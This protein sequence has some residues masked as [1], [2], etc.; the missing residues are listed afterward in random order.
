MERTWTSTSWPRR[1]RPDEPQPLADAPDLPSANASGRATCSCAPPSPGDT[2]MPKVDASN[3]TPA[4]IAEQ[5]ERLEAQGAQPRVVTT[6]LWRSRAELR[7]A[8]QDAADE[9]RLANLRGE[10][11][12]GGGRTPASKASR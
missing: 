10:A 1:P 4:M 11:L 5:V 6:I 2:L 12:K 8:E 7:Q 3:W 9:R